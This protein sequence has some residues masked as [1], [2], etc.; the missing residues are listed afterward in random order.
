M[1]AKEPVRPD[2]ERIARLIDYELG[3]PYSYDESGPEYQARMNEIAGHVV[4][5][6]IGNL[7]KEAADDA[8]DEE[9][10][11]GTTLWVAYVTAGGYIDVTWGSL[12]NWLESKKVP[13]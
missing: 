12:D 10:E 3:G 9:D 4:N 7:R 1:S 11:P 5:Q 2:I 13:E 8:Y 6:V